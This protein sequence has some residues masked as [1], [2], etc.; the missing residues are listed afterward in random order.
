MT[1]KLEGNGLWESSR[2]MLPEHKALFSSNQRSSTAKLPAQLS[3]EEMNLV[4]DYILL[5]V[6]LS[7][8]ENKSREIEMSSLAFKM[9]Y[10]A[11]SRVLASIIGKDLR[12]VEKA[13]QERSIQVFEEMKDE[14]MLQYRY[15]CRGH[16]EPL[17][18]ARDYMKSE[19]SVRIGRYAKNLVAIIQA[20]ERG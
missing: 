7:V 2:M 16:E 12:K 6:M 5:P 4:R 19:I 15:I 20:V 3:K 17:I 14:N 11:S 10:S 13:L 9:L 8:V 18:M 1:K